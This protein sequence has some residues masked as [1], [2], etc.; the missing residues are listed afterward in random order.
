MSILSNLSNAASAVSKA[1]LNT[2]TMFT[3]FVQ[4][5]SRNYYYD[6]AQEAAH[7]I[8]AL[9]PKERKTS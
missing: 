4:I 8:A 9:F 2:E 5:V 7:L 1:I 3:A 6:L